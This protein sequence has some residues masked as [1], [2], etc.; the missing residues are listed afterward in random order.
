LKGSTGV[1]VHALYPAAVD[2]GALSNEF[3]EQVTA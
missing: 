2:H 3:E 1:L